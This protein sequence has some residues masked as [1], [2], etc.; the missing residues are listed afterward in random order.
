MTPTELSLLAMLTAAAQLICST[1]LLFSFSLLPPYPPHKCKCRAHT[2]LCPTACSR[3]NCTGA[4]CCVPRLV[5]LSPVH[6]LG[7]HASRLSRAVAAAADQFTLPA[8]SG[9]VCVGCY[10]SLRIVCAAVAAD[11]R[12]ASGLLL[13]LLCAALA[14]TAN[15]PP[16]MDSLA[17]IIACVHDIFKK[18][19]LTYFVSDNFAVFLSV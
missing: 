2:R 7:P 10:L 8:A 11:F 12:A 15:G 19:R 17:L 1:A 9:K 3:S 14:H 6:K 18:K 13:Q 16:R 4:S 5:S